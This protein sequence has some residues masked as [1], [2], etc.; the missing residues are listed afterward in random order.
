MTKE[1][2]MYVVKKLHKK[3]EFRNV[4]LNKNKSD[5]CD[6]LMSN[7]GTNKWEPASFDEANARIIHD[8]ILKSRK[9]LIDEW[10][11]DGVKDP[12]ICTALAYT[13]PPSCADTIEERNNKIKPLML[14]HL[15]NLMNEAKI[16][17]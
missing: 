4:M 12:N 1:L 3:P 13:C 15:S 17:K 6:V 2:V 16:Q 14:A 7:N 8:V 10:E 5:L 9:A 11:Y